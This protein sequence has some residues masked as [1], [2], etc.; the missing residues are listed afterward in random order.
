MWAATATTKVATRLVRRPRTLCE[1]RVERRSETCGWRSTACPG[2]PG[3]RCSTGSART[4]SSSARTPTAVASARCSPRTGPAV[5]RASYRSLGRGTGSR[6]ATRAIGVARR[7]TERE[8]LIL[9]SHLES[10]L[11]AE[12]MPD[13]DLAA[14]V[15]EHRELLA[16]R[17]RRSGPAGAAERGAQDRRASERPGDRD[18]S[19]E[20]RSR[21][22]WAWL[23]VFRR[24][25]EYEQALER[26]Y[27][28]RGALDRRDER[29]LVG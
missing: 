18:R 4:R 8:L 29:E 20:L 17:R 23:R 2:R 10:S 28:E 11:I 27:A 21:H 1:H 5:A 14:A 15:A 19:K 26:V 6:S 3:S 16:R 13:Q 7:A 24:Y 12:D 9:R 25:E 22:G